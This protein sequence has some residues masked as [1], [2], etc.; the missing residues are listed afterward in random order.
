MYVRTE[1]WVNELMSHVVNKGVN[2]RR[3]GQVNGLAS[4]N[5]KGRMDKQMNDLMTERLMKWTIQRIRERIVQWRSCQLMDQ[6]IKVRVAVGKRGFS[7]LRHVQT[8]CRA[9]SSSYRGFFHEEWNGWGVKLTSNLHIV[10]RLECVEAIPLP[11]HT[12]LLRNSL[13]ST[14]AVCTCT[15]L[16]KEWKDLSEWIAR[17]NVRIRR[18]RHVSTLLKLY[19]L[20][21]S[22]P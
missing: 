17:Y 11:R 15:G 22:Q 18:L 16:L 13:Y 5:A 8:H 9:P 14:R 2:E 4:E 19:K 12:F 3:I 7:L 21:M 1:W 6:G 20:I 10:L